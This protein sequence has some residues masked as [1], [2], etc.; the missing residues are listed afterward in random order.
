MTALLHRWPVLVVVL[1]TGC[2]TYPD[3]PVF[4]YGRTLRTDGSPFS[5]ATLSFERRTNLEGP[6]AAGETSSTFTPYKAV[7]TTAEGAFTLEL[8]ARDA[9]ETLPT[10]SQTYRFRVCTPPEQGA[11]AVASFIFNA[12]DIE[13]PALKPWDAALTVRESATGPIVIFGPPPPAPEKPPSAK[14]PAIFDSHG[15]PQLTT[16]TVPTPVVQLT[17]GEALLWQEPREP[18]AWTPTPWVLEDF[19]ELQVQLRALSMGEWKFEPL[20]GGSSEVTFRLEWGSQREPLPGGTLQ[21]LSRGAT[22]APWWEPGPCPWTDGQL[23][24]ARLSDKQQEP[25]EVGIVLPAPAHLSRAVIR[26]LRAEGGFFPNQTLIIEGTENGSDWSQLASIPIPRMGTLEPRAPFASVGRLWAA[27][28]PLDGPLMLNGSPL[29]LDVPLSSTARVRQ[30]RLYA[31]NPEG[32]HTVLDSL[33][34]FSLF[35]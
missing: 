25:T 29:F 28:S 21:P 34:E 10:G 2:E 32:R 6:D 16:P 14:L 20:W 24:P 19:A 11:M 12:Q 35:E 3:Q 27:D 15:T 26:G 33:A 13:L 31:E 7:T 1:V 5:N 18:G 4:V 22:C 30:V 9:E 17:S 8:L 23:A